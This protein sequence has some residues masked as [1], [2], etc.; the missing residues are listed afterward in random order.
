[1]KKFI[2]A[3]ITIALGLILATTAIT[4]KA[5]KGQEIYAKKLEKICKISGLK[6]SSKHTQEEWEKIYD[7]HKLNSEIKKLCNGYDSNEKDLPHIYDFVYHHAK[8]KK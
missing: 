8:L 5:Q 1:M 7:A 2:T 4:A 6:F 3:P